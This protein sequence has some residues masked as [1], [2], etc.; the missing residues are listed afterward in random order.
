MNY[1][2]LL[3]YKGFRLKFR[4]LFHYAK[5]SI[6]NFIY[7]LFFDAKLSIIDF[8]C[9]LFFYAIEYIENYIPSKYRAN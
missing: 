1:R 9:D 4:D 7:D 6:I 5:L 2:Y 8:I 3:Y